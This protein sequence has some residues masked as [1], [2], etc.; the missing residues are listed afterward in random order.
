[1]GGR[2][3][4]K[5]QQVEADDGWTV[6]T[7]GLSKLSVGN[8]KGK[9]KGNGPRYNN[10][11]QAGSMPAATVDGLTA[12]K[13]LRDFNNRTEKWEA[14]AC[15]Q[16]LQGVL[17]KTEWGVREAVC[18]GIGSFSRDWEHRHRAMWQ[19]VLFVSVVSR[20]RK[21]NVE[22][23]LYA[24]EP[25]FTPL[26]HAFLSLLDVGVCTKDIETHIT[27]RSFVFS[28]FVDWYILL[29]IFLKGK[30][31]VLYVGNEILDDYGAFAQSE[32]KREKQEEC[33]ELGRKW[34]VKRDM[35]TGF[36]IVKG[37]E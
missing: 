17:A 31:P 10:A 29:P 18:I 34:L 5:R 35:F 25:A 14:T 20:L 26:D 9:G 22:V 15:A 2:G 6:I 19:L 24:Q 7:H 33:N 21:N 4:V 28:P 13:L 30:D 11:S 1:M 3:R 8:K 27:N 16:H 23:K 36:R 12:E 37:M 32:E